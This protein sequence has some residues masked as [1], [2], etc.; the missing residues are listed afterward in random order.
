MSSMKR[1]R[2]TSAQQ[3]HGPNRFKRV[4]IF[5][6]RPIPSDKCPK[7]VQAGHVQPVAE[8]AYRRLTLQRTA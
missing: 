4:P 3:G 1:T 2:T 5:G 8:R 7:H 6:R